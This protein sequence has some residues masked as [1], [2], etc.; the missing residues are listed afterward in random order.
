[1]TVII[2]LIDNVWDSFFL[3]DNDMD[4]VSD[5]SMQEKEVARKKSKPPFLHLD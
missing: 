5:D 2:S 1:M 3:S 4:K